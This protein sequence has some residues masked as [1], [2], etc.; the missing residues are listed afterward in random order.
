MDH[1]PL[2]WLDVFL[3]TF[4]KRISPSHANAPHTGTRISFFLHTSKV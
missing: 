2:G 3:D 4:R 1:Y